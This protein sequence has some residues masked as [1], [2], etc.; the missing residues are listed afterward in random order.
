MGK[1]RSRKKS[2]FGVVF[3]IAAIL[4]VTIILLFNLPA[5]RQVLESTDFVDVV[6]EPRDRQTEESSD[7]P[8]LELPDESAPSGED[9]P[10]EPSQDTS[11]PDSSSQDGPADPE[12]PDRQDPGDDPTVEL[13][14]DD[15]DAPEIVVTPPE[16]SSPEGQEQTRSATLYFIRVSDDGRILA[17]PVQ[18]TVRFSGGPLT[19]TIQALISGPDADDH[20]DGLLSLI[21]GGTELLS[22]RVADGVAY[23]N[24]NEAFRFNTMGLEGY[25]A[26]MRQVVETA[27]EFSTVERVQILINGQIVEYLGGDGIYI[28]T[29]LSPRDLRR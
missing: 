24:F 17:V 14:G 11:S 15:D 21:P 5:I 4:L 23:L 3:W 19:A 18:R 6:F 9:G 26:Q 25:L 2:S 20:N 13:P 22:A 27:A 1:E 7:P 10:D 29:P 12:A 28:G 16:E 8:T